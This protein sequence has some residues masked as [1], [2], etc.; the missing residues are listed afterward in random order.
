MKILLT[1]SSG[2]L[3]KA[4]ISQKPKDFELLC[5]K[6]NELD[7][8][9]QINCRSYIEKFQ[10]AYVINCG[11]FTNVDLAEKES[12]L[13]FAINTNA[14][15]TFANVLKEYGGN[16]LQISTDYVFDGCK[17]SPYEVKDI[18]N[19]ISKYGLSKAICEENIEKILKPY[20]QLI[21]LRT[22][23]LLGP[24]G[25]NFLSTMIKL[26]KEKNLFPVISDQVGAMSSTFDVAKIC[27]SIINN[28][29]LISKINYMNHWTCDG[30]TSWYDIAIAIG[31]IATKYQIL[32]SPA[33]I[34]P[35]KTENYPTL[36]KR[37]RY[38]ILDCSPTKDILN[39]KG[40]YW[41]H[42]LEDIISKMIN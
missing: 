6:R 26:H 42:E 27:W 7:L 33:E 29:N 41:R 18:R 16:F 24:S 23:W 32:K 37:P 11:A 3:G 9:D 31:D 34:I 10:P 25:K 39:V 21:I 20:G 5:P 30:I 13:C 15:I 14:P 12:D 4:I 28:W 22:S 38:S 1:G 19:P 36:A 35:I 40:K 17:N 2:Q 8:S